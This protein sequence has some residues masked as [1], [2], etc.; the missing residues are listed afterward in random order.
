MQ[1]SCPPL[2]NPP[3]SQKERG[4][5]LG[6]RVRLRRIRSSLRSHSD[7]KMNWITGATPASAVVLPPVTEPW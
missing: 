2:R 5:V 3:P 1:E 4:A 7:L 6:R